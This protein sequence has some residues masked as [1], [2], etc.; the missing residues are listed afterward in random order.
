MSTGCINPDD[1]SVLAK[2]LNTTQVLVTVPGSGKVYKVALSDLLDAFFSVSRQ[3]VRVNVAEGLQTINFVD[4]GTVSYGVN[5]LEAQTATGDVLSHV[6]S[7]KQT[8]S[9]DITVPDAGYI[10]FKLEIHA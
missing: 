9:F 4:I 2:I 5:V 1:L 10:I 6:V 3:A 7:N 8:N